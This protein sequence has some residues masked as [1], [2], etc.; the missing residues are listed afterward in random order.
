M[1]FVYSNK[2]ILVFNYPPMRKRYRL[3]L[4]LLVMSFSAE[5]QFDT[6]FMMARIRYCADSL[7]IGFKTKNWDLFTRYTNPALVGTMGGKQAFIGYVSQTFG[8]VPEGAWKRYDAGR[9][10]QVV[11]TP[12]DLQ[13]IIELYS[14]VEAMDMRI[15]DTS[16]LVA[17][18]W[19]GGMFWTFFDSQGD[20]LAARSIKPDLSDQLKIPGKHEHMESTAPPAKKQ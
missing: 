14:V 19:D 15:T 13:G 12:A 10:L 5:A 17:Q 3:L 11:K 7:S 4:P 20:V 18:S 2:V 9:V 8:R 1:N 6:T 16:Y